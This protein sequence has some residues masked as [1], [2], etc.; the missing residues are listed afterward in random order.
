MRTILRLA[1]DVFVLPDSVSNSSGPSSIVTSDI[2]TREAE[3]SRSS[4]V[5]HNLRLNCLSYSLAIDD[6]DSLRT[7]APVLWLKIHNCSGSAC[8]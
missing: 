3:T 1:V 8:M 5:W 7:T 4:G 6:S 2:E